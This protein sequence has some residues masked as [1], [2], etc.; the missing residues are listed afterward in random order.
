M[1]LRTGDLLFNLAKKS[2]NYRPLTSE[3]LA[4]LKRCYVSIM[5]DFIAVCDKYNL[6]YIL[7]YGTC[8]GSVRHKGFIPWDDDVDLAMPR[9]DYL[10]FLEL[11]DEELGEK[12]VIKSISKGDKV[13]Y[14]TIH[15]Y[16]KGSKYGGLEDV[17]KKLEEVNS[18]FIDIFPYDNV[19]DNFILR[20]SQAIWS[21][22]IMFLASCAGVHYRVKTMKKGGIIFSPEERKA[23]RLKDTIGIL[24]GMISANTWARLNEWVT[25]L[26]KND[27]SKYISCFCAAK[28]LSTFNHIRANIFGVLGGDKL[29]RV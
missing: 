19:P 6:N 26:C 27:K 29:W 17:D 1:A 25:R 15:M 7:A 9:K 13:D 20:Y 5:A 11:A 16:L 12:Y 10:R 23:L 3:E 4:R 21:L 22:G 2:Q 18:I 24:A 14:P 8:L 28:K